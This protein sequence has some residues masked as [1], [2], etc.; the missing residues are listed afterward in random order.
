LARWPV[1]GGH[2]ILP[3][4]IND[5]AAF[6]EY[7]DRTLPEANYAIDVPRHVLDLSQP[8][9]QSIGDAIRWLRDLMDAA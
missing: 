4:V 6:A 5:W 1:V 9:E 8:A 7:R 3:V 2:E